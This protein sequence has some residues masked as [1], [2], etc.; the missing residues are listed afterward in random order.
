MIARSF[1]K[2]ALSLTAALLADVINGTLVF[3]AD[4]SFVYTHDGSSATGDSFTY[5][6]ELLR[7]FSPSAEVRGHWGQG[8]GM[9]GH[10]FGYVEVMPDGR[11]AA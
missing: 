3:N 11:A 10:Y 6:V 5:P 8:G 9:G 7:V 1:K 4:G 2:V